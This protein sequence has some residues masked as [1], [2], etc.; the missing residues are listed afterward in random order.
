MAYI[1]KHFFRGFIAVWT[2]QEQYELVLVFTLN[3]LL[4]YHRNMYPY[5]KHAKLHG[6]FSADIEIEFAVPWVV[7]IKMVSVWEVGTD[8]ISV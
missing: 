1:L 6:G 7:E 5:V 2:R 8:L 3:V 4:L